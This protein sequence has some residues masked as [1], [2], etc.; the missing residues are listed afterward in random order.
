MW[1]M[2]TR[3]GLGSDERLTGKVTAGMVVISA[4]P[5]QHL[6]KGKVVW[7]GSTEALQA[8]ASILERYLGV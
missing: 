5:A 3:D 6:E 1:S 8:D 7:N 4:S 2:T